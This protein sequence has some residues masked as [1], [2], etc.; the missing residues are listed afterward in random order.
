MANQFCTTQDILKIDPQAGYLNAT[1]NA[2]DFKDLIEFASEEIVQLLLSANPNYGAKTIKIEDLVD[3]SILKTPTIHRVLALL[4]GSASIT[5][6]N[7]NAVIKAKEH[8]E[9][10]NRFLS[11]IKIP[12]KSG[13]NY[14]FKTV[15]RRG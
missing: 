5:K 13:E 7:S 12:L 4:Y 11:T 6:S 1:P 2:P 10:F 15:V 14:Q 3:V 8:K 9:D